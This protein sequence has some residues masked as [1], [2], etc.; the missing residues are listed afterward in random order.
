MIEAVPRG[1]PTNE[2]RATGGRAVT[3]VR[4]RWA[5]LGRAGERGE[6]PDAPCNGLAEQLVQVV[7]RVKPAQDAPE[8]VGLCGTGAVDAERIIAARTA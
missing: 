8:D 3:Y 1:G 7:D 5:K 4:D 6:G 2:M